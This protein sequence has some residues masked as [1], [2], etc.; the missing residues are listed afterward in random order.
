MLAMKMGEE[1]AVSRFL[2]DGEVLK[3]SP[4]HRDRARGLAWAELLLPTALHPS[5]KSQEARGEGQMEN[6]PVRATK[7]LV[8]SGTQAV[9]EFTQRRR[10]RE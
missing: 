8:W 2:R 10:Y 1:K 9:K 7:M 5:R 3:S 6:V 4:N